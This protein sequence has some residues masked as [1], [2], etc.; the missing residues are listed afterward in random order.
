MYLRKLRNEWS[1][2]LIGIGCIGLIFSFAYFLIS[3]ASSIG[4][5]FSL[6]TAG[7]WCG[8]SIIMVMIGT[9]IAEGK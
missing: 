9:L 6:L 2:A 5:F 3:H 8:I 1:R 7:E 4:N